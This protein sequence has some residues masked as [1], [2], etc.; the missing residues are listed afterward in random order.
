MQV[1]LIIIYNHQYNKNIDILEKLYEDRFNNIYH[2]VPFYT[3]TKSNVISVYENSLYFQGYVAQALKS[4]FSNQFEHYFFIGDDLILNPII[5]QNNYKKHLKLN[6]DTSFIPNLLSLHELNYYWGNIILAYKYKIY[7]IGVEAVN[8]LPNYSKALLKFKKFNLDVENLRFEQLYKKPM[9]KFKRS[10]L[11]QVFGFYWLKC[12]SKLL[13]KV[14]RLPYPLVGSYSDIFVISASSIKD[15]CHYCGVF[16][17]TNLHVEI[18]IPTAIVLTSDEI[19]TEKDLVLQGKAL[20][21]TE[22]LKILEKYNSDL[23]DL[24]SDFPENNLYI[25][26]VKLSRWKTN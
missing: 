8:Q 14:Y 6:S 23:N 15:F 26:P 24:L 9:V 13:Q 22:D 1:A 12:K 18:A 7:T 2:I 20:W 16:A 17:A 4:F 21:T 10:S 19:V 11:K 3:G 25:H 5:N